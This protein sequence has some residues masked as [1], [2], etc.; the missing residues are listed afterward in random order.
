MIFSIVFLFLGFIVHILVTGLSVLNY[1]FPVQF[2]QSLAVVFNI[3]GFLG[4]FLP[5]IATIVAIIGLLVPAYV[6]R[7]VFQLFL[8]AFAFIPFIGKQ[9]NYP[10]LGS[11]SY[12][13]GK[14]RINRS[15]RMPQTHEKRKIKS[16]VFDD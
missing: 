8:F 7:Y 11:M 2:V 9:V 14:L 6:V 5:F 16:I 15:Q 4:Q 3:I 1:S 10:S 13:S 12:G